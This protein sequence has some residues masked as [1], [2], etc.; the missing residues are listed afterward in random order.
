VH[1]YGEE[2]KK[3][4]GFTA[5]QGIEVGFDSRESLRLGGRESKLTVAQKKQVEKPCGTKYQTTREVVALFGITLPT[6]YRAL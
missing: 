3:L 1:L 6:T 4:G 5:L 2:L